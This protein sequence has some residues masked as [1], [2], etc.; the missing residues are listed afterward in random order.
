[1]GVH[2]VAQADAQGT[3]CDGSAQRAEHGTGNGADDS[4]GRTGGAAPEGCTQLDT[5][6]GPGGCAC[7]TRYGAQR[8]DHATSEVAGLDAR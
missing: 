7:G 8:A 3:A 5:Y 1:M 2:D 4:T 6:P